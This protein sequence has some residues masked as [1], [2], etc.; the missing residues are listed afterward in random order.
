MTADQVELLPETIQQQVRH[1]RG[2]IPDTF[3]WF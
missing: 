2:T 3:E 1:G